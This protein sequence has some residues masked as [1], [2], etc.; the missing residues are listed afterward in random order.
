MVCVS[1]ILPTF[2]RVEML[3]RAAK[4]VLAQTFDDLELIIVDDAS[5]EDIESMVRSIGDPR[6]TYIRRPLNGGAAAARNTGIAAAKGRFVAF[7]DSDD[8]WLPQKLELQLSLMAAQP[9][10]VGVVTGC[11]ILCGGDLHLFSPDK[12]VVAPNPMTAMKPGEDQVKHL[13]S[14]NR[15]SVQNALFRRECVSGSEWFDACARANEDWEFAVR[16][17]QRWTIF[18]HPDI[19]VLAFTYTDSVSRSTRRQDIGMVRILRKNRAIRSQ[20]P[21]EFARLLFYIG[22]RRWAPG[23]RRVALKFMLAGARQQPAILCRII[24]GKLRRLMRFPRS[25]ALATR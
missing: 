24:S 11:K 10:H 4:S 5:S 25:S 17:A 19:V 9:V 14:D 2:N 18:E 3:G 13:L 1:V 21:G 20:Y 7:Q 23:K 6:V 15:I 12:I 16:L 8:L 22:R